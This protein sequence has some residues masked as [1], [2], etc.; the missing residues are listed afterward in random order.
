MKRAAR[1]EIDEKYRSFKFYSREDLQNALINYHADGVTKKSVVP[2]SKWDVRSISN[3]A[4]LF[5]ARDPTDIINTRLV[6]ENI[7]FSNFNEYIGSWNVSKVTNMEGMFAIAESFNQD[8]SE[9]NVENVTNYGNFAI[10]TPI[11]N[12]DNI[13][14]RFSL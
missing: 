8:I 2:I 5:W 12:T 6:I 7:T 9:W 14:P 13:P 1:K 11:E 4:V 10:G 3:M